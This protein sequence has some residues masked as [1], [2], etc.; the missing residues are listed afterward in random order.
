MEH[1]MF[2]LLLSVV[3]AGLLPQAAPAQAPNVVTR[4]S[5][6]TATVDR[7]ERSSRVVTFRGEGNTLQSVFVEPDVAA[8][9]DLQVG[10][11]VTVRYVESVIVQVRPDR[12]S[13]GVR[14]TTEEARKEGGD[15]VIAQSKAFVTIEKI[16]VQA[17]L[18]SYR[19]KDGLRGARG[20][21]D[22]RLL[23]GLRPGDRVEITLTR[24]RAVDIQRKK[25]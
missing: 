15:P 10:D 2:K 23:E 14:D 22:K 19:T 9:D 8:F 5:A 16:D 11:V 17:L 4:E 6:V 3:V 25:Q 13:T 24:E 12:Q 1:L 18:V 21:T 7:I 20:V